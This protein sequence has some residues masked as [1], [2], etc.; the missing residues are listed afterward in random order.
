MGLFCFLLSFGF[1]KI[2]M[3]KILLLLPVTFLAGCGPAAEDRAA[4]HRQ[5][6]RFQDSIAHVIRMQMSEA[7]PNAANIPR[8]DKPVTQATVEPNRFSFQPD[9]A[10]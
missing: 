7:D 8:P 4:M 2:I 5:A 3:K 10:K 9:S 6:K 1:L